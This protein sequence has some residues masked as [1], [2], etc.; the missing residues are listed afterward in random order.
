MSRVLGSV[1]VAYDSYA[2]GDPAGAT[3]R[4]GKSGLTERWTTL[5]RRTWFATA[6][7]VATRRLF[8][9]LEDGVEIVDEL[10]AAT[11]THRP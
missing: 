7:K 6:A 5:A 10:A 3:A 1:R 9:D 2:E 11:P 4:C 8:C